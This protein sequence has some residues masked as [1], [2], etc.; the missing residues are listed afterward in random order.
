MTDPR[1]AHLEGQLNDIAQN[2]GRLPAEEAGKPSQATRLVGTA[3][4][5][6]EFFHAP[7][8]KTFATFV[9]GGHSETHLV[10]SNQFRT[11]LARCLYELDGR[12]PGSQALQD[13]I[14]VLSGQALYD[15]AEQSVS[16]RLGGDDEVIYLD[17]GDPSWSAIEITATGWRVVSDP[18]ARMRR[19]SGFGALPV[20]ERGG[21][22][23]GLRAFV[24]V[25]SDADWHLLVGYLIG[26][27]RA[28]G[29]YP[30]MT[31]YGEHGSAK[32][33]TA[34]TVRS[35]IDPNAGRCERSRG[36][37]ET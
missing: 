19:P 9:V 22:L 16:V 5:R 26:S 29:P 28:R 21:S 27:L 12:A 33:T 35:L 34:R 15:G 32:S 23:E 20:P 3:L 13:A 25:G 14:G 37:P 7:D 30:V 24:N 17:L 36:S 1:I 18:P 8:G 10:R 11:W 31:L 6:A 2:N 4:E